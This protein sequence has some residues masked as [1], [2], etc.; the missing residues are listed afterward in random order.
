VNTFAASWLDLRE[1]ADAAAR[2]RAVMNACAGYFA[3]RDEITVCDVGCG[4]GAALRALAP[5]LPHRQTWVLIDKDA[6][7]L[8]AA[9][10]RLRAWADAVRETSDGL[11]LSCGQTLIYVRM[12]MTDVSGP[13]ALPPDTTLVSLSAL[14]D[15]TSG[16]WMHAIVAAATARGLPIFASLIFDGTVILDPPDQDDAPVLQQFRRDM[17]R[18]KGFGPAAGV[19]AAAAFSRILTAAG[20]GVEAG[21]SDWTLGQSERPLM[22]AMIDGIATAATGTDLSGG[23]VHAWRQ[24]RNQLRGLTV[25]H[26][27]LF[28]SPPANAAAR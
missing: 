17:Q 18:D 27:D 20:Y 8:A 5:H 28:A 26:L 2:N 25:G 10:I 23:A 14:L 16:A 12:R 4:T 1:P 15:L 13:W 3:Q 19:D 24:R 7:L 11:D 22:L 9:A 6:A 21:R